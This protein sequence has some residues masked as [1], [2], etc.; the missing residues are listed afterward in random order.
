MPNAPARRTALALILPV[1]AGAAAGWGQVSASTAPTSVPQPV[2]VPAVAPNLIMPQ[3]HR[4]P[5]AWAT[6]SIAAVAADITI[7][8][9]VA[10]TTLEISVHNP[11][12]TP[13][14]AELLLPV[15]D[16]VTVRGLQYDGTGPEPTARLLPREEAR[17]IYNSIV[18]ASRDPALLEFAGL[19]V[20]RSSAFPV[21]AGATQKIRITFE[22]LLPSDNGRIDY[23]LP[24]SESLATGV[25]VPWA[26]RATVRSTR[27]ISSVY[28]PSHDLV[29]ERRSPGEFVV[30]VP[31]NS[32]SGAGSFRLSMMAPQDA[33]AASASVY[34]YPDAAIDG[35]KGG[36]FLLVAALPAQKPADVKP[37]QRE[38]TVVID[39][40]GSMR[41]EKFRQAQKAAENILSGLAAGEKFNIVDYSDSIESFA[42]DPVTLDDKSRADALAYLGR[43]QADG[44]TNLHDALLT[45][46]N[47]PASPNT[48]PLV[49]FLTDGLPTVG[50]RGEAAIRDHALAANKASRRIFTFGVGFDVNTPLL[51][52]LARAAKGA[53]T[54]VLPTEDVE[55]KVSQV[56]R[57]LNGPTM[58]NATLTVLDGDGKPSTRILREL[59]PSGLDD[60]FEG[61]QVVVLGQY[62]GA[63]DTLHLKLEGDYFGTRRAF[64]LSLSLQS[65]TT[66]NGYVPRL[67]ATRKIARL[68][69]ELRQ[70][71]ADPSG[72]DARS[73]ELLD[74]I[75]QLSMRWGVMT[76]Y[77]SFLATEQN[78]A[79]GDATRVRRMAEDRWASTGGKRSGAEG[80]VQEADAAGKRVALNAQ[81]A[82]TTYAPA[83]PAATPSAPAARGGGAN[84]P[85]DAF[86]R[87]SLKAGDAGGQVVYAAVQNINSQTYYRRTDRW[88]DGRALARESEK[89]E[90]EVTVGTKEFDAVA[91]ALIAE[92]QE[93]VLALEGDILTFAAGE[94]TLIHPAK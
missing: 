30:T 80:V 52:G 49:L 65:A 11:G 34:A 53:P 89:P 56:Y 8:D 67:W 14:E 40:S 12:G 54:Y 92:G 45:A 87:E 47:A 35:G 22:Q 27:A 81:S 16:G 5:R 60:I 59:E 2:T 26:I 50:E 3:T 69:E 93:G 64:D 71:G 88:V 84:A 25:G 61:D 36:Y 41:G 6:V 86:Y 94:R 32:A 78:V 91:D 20:I 33:A 90:V 19:N 18:H 77:T 73:K 76:P 31:A 38:V 75:T 1:I 55:Q 39:R 51:S 24:K 42:K 17:R 58:A 57:R 70:S 46:L 13:Q 28:S 44:G 48:M 63:S 21:P 74:Q 7:N 29:S 15:P 9:Q 10:T 83:R 79:I 72:G 85:A 23:V 43:L 4:V 66:R 82:N 62:T 37:V 68:V